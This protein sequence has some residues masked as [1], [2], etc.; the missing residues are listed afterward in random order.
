[1]QLEKD[2]QKAADGSSRGLHPCQLQ[3]HNAF[4]ARVF[5]LTLARDWNV[6][7]LSSGQKG[8]PVRFQGALATLALFHL[9]HMVQTGMS[10]QDIARLH[11]GHFPMLR[12]RL[13]SI[14]VID[15]AMR[16]LK[17]SRR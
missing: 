15:L 8:T 11:D 12:S 5:S 13:F 3:P 6:Q 9:E 2:C 16:S 7:L 17:I 14:L 4:L 10:L 1:M